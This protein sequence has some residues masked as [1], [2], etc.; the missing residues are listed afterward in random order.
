[1][2]RGL[3]TL[4]LAA[5][6][7]LA[8]L[9]AGCI[10]YVA[11]DEYG[12]VMSLGVD[13]GETQA[14]RFCFIVQIE[15]A[16]G[17]ND[18]ENVV[19]SAEGDNIYDAITTAEVSVPYLLNFGR[20][21]YILFSEEIAQSGYIT[22]F[23]DESFKNLGVRRSAKLMIVLDDC[24]DYCIGVISK[25]YPNT[26]KR[27]YSILREYTSEGL[28]PITN[29]AAFTQ[30]VNGKRGDS[31]LTLGATDDSI[32]AEDVPGSSKDNE[33]HP[34][35]T[36]AGVERTGGLRS[37]Y[38][39]CAVFDGDIMKGVLNGHDTQLILMARGTFGS[40]RITLNIGQTGSMVLLLKNGGKPR[41]SLVLAAEPYMHM[42]LKLQ[43]SIESGGGEM[44][45]HEWDQSI[46]P[47]LEAYLEKELA[48]VFFLCREMNSDAFELGKYAVMQFSSTAAW[49]AYDWK[50]QYA[51][52]NAEFEV[53][54]YIENEEINTIGG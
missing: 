54:L 51:K 37:Y 46:K 14:Y 29:I 42:E 41:I 15:G 10:K 3:K 48:R 38:M 34:F 23:V 47:M 24:L 11:L 27:Q 17:E 45:Y 20:T 21:N 30:G 4:L 50:A 1:M 43:C 2:K 25:D 5:A 35:D 13:K 36:T 9:N 49:E 31:I 6:L 7:L 40:G 22:G 16:K 19:L 18:A 39:G 44:S 52:T 33:I 26:S 8:S 28:T 53:S 32:P 12:Y